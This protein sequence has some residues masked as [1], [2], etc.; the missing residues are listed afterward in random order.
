V[1]HKFVNYLHTY[2]LTRTHMGV[3]VCHPVY[4]IRAGK[5]CW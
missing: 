4:E 5:L 2:P 1:L 3:L